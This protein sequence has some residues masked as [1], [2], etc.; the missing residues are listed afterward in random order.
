MVGGG[1]GG[2]IR[3]RVEMRGNRHGGGGEKEKGV[4][5]LKEGG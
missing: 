2:E 3:Q 5:W 4:E 1:G